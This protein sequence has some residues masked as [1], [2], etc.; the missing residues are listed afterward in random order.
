[1]LC[2]KVMDR[3]KLPASATAHAQFIHMLTFQ[4]NLFELFKSTCIFSNI[5]DSYLSSI[6]MTKMSQLSK[7]YSLT[8]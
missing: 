8:D 4:R 1:M 3:I 2:L 6:F 5:F 7:N